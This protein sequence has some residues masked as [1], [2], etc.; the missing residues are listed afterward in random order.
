M[1]IFDRVF[2]AVWYWLGK[3]GISIK[4]KDNRKAIIAADG[5]YD[6]YTYLISADSTSYGLTINISVMST[7]IEERQ[8]RFRLGG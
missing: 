5:C 2:S 7:H 4:I 8:R 3:Y 6:K 1:G